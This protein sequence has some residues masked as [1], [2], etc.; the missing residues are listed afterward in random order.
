[1]IIT[2]D[3]PLSPLEVAILTKNGWACKIQEDEHSYTKLTEETEA[4][5]AEKEFNSPKEALFEIE[6][7][8]NYDIISDTTQDG[9]SI[10]YFTWVDDGKKGAA[11][12]DCAMIMYDAEETPRET[13]KKYQK[14]KMEN[15]I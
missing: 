7:L 1:M 14:L 4:D 11:G 10:H 6:A 12:W 15:N 8:L 9:C 3:K 2:Y 5:F 13:A